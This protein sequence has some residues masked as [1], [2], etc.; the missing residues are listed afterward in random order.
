M[1]EE[2]LVGRGARE[3]AHPG[4]T[5]LAHL[6][7]TRD[8]LAVWGARPVL[9]LAGLTHAVYGTDGYPHPLVAVAERP[10][11]VRLLG[12]EAEAIVYAY[13]ALDR[14]FSYPRLL[15]GVVR[16][17]FTGEQVRID[18]PLVRDLVELT[19]ATELDVMAQN[20]SLRKRHAVELRSR[21]TTWSGHAS[22]PA[23][24]ALERLHP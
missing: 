7:R 12:P 11:L 6:A 9:Q 19:F 14:R 23:V 4:G 22:L 1:I 15:S 2:F 16:D 5:L 18:S 13:C 10:R 21:L 17:R 20:P 3:Q 24:E 8:S